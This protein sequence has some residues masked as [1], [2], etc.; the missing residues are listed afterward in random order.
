[1]SKNTEGHD[2]KVKERN[3]AWEQ[4][5]EFSTEIFAKAGMRIE[6]A[7]IE[8]DALVWANLRGVDSHGIMRIPWYIEN[9]ETRVM[10]PTPDIRIEVDTPAVSLI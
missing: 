4:L 2:M 6:D 8:A 9:I 7:K 5:L 1:M 10:N 3:V